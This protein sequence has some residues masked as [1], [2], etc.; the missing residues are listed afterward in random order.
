MA[1]V[2]LPYRYKDE[3]GDEMI[4]ASGLISLHKGNRVAALNAPYG[5]DAVGLAEA[6]LLAGGVVSHTVVSEADRQ[7][8]EQRAAKDAARSMRKRA[9]AALRAGNWDEDPTEP[10]RALPLL[11]GDTARGADVHVATP[12]GITPCGEGH[13]DVT[14]AGLLAEVTCVECLR[15]IAVERGEQVDKLRSERD[16]ALRELGKAL[17]AERAEHLTVQ[18]HGTAHRVAQL[19]KDV[20]R[21]ERDR[22]ED[23]ARLALLDGRVRSTEAD[24]GPVVWS[25]EAAPGGYVCAAP[26]PSGICGQ[27][28]ESEPC[29][30]HA[31][32][33]QLAAAVER[34]DV[35]ESTDRGEK[36]PA[37]TRVDGEPGDDDEYRHCGATSE[38]P[39]GDEYACARRVGHDGRCSPHRDPVEGC[40]GQ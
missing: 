12:E 14:V 11:S 27:P 38:L 22:A 26:T 37:G 8:W 30:E 40:D 17:T 9:V 21:L 15:V 19:E 25:D 10:V 36:V 33:G 5:P 39:S 13:H 32:A 18:Q 28:I 20:G 16:V 6:S 35:L 3:D 31:L 2:K 24:L 34:L 29:R 23:Q 7:A 1:D 4:V